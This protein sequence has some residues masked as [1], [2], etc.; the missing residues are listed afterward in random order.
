MSN[1]DKERDIELR[2]ASIQKELDAE[3]LH[4]IK[5]NGDIRQLQQQLQEAKN[6][7]MAATRLNDQLEHGQLTIERLNNESK[8]QKSVGFETFMGHKDAQSNIY[9]FVLL[10]SYFLSL[11]K[12]FFYRLYIWGRVHKKKRKLNVPKIFIIHVSQKLL[13]AYECDKEFHLN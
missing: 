6:G 7:L 10:L 11:H 5:L 2:T 8:L 1:L 4:Q 12:L 13:S 9:L 3:R